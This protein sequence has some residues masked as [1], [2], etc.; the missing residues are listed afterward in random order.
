M[1][2]SELYDIDRTSQDSWFDPILSLDTRLYIDP[3]LLYASET[4]HFLG[5]HD[6]IVKFFNAM[7][8]MIAE[9]GGNPLSARYRRATS[10]MVF[11]EVSELCLGYTSAGT[12]GSGSGRGLSRIIAEAL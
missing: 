9:S 11:P 12:G 8:R 1:K 10:C 6:T 4:G 5:S 3:F 2:F 7:F